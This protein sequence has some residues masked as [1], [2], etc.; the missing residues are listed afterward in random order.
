MQFEMTMHLRQGVTFNSK[1][2]FMKKSISILLILLVLAATIFST[3]LTHTPAETAEKV[4]A[5]PC[6]DNMI[7][8]MKY[9]TQFPRGALNPEIKY[10]REFIIRTLNELGFDVIT[11]EFTFEVFDREAFDPLWIEN[12]QGDIYDMNPPWIVEKAGVNIIATLYPNTDNQTEDILI[13][14]AHYDTVND[15]VGANDNASG[16][17]VV[18]ELAGLLVNAKTDT[19]LRFIFFDGEEVGLKGSMHYV[20]EMT[21][22]ELGRTIGILNFDMLAGMQAEN[23]QVYSADGKENFLFH[24]LQGIEGFET[25]AIADFEVGASDHVPFHY[26]YIPG[27]LFSHDIIWEHY[28][29]EYDLMEYICKNMLMEA[30]NAGLGIIRKIISTQ[31]DSFIYV[32]RGTFDKEITEPSAWARDKITKAID[33]GLLPMSL[34][35]YYTHEITMAEFYMLLDAFGFEPRQIWLYLDQTADEAQAALIIREDAAVILTHLLSKLEIYVIS[36]NHNFNDEAGLS[37][38]SKAALNTVF[39]AS[40]MLGDGLNNFRPHEALTRE[41]A[42]TIAM[43]LLKG[44][45]L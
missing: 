37:I 17:A 44:S 26:V 2:G 35:G 9:L 15:V 10:A 32:A 11:Q 22:E 34:R 19:Q 5:D 41:Q 6:I 40:L 28:H 33:L 43:R 3:G 7:A 24:I 14:A 16:V 38:S 1:A 25:V 31:T 23:V 29:N 12:Y 27:L 30:A 18:L 8:T 21:Y 42:I 45:F 39:S 13:I 20:M 36:A 4:D